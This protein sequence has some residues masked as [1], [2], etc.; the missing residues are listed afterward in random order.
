MDIYN[1]S[2]IISCLNLCCQQV[3]MLVYRAPA[4]VQ[5]DTD[6]VQLIGCHTVWHRSSAA[7]WSAS[8]AGVYT[9]TAA[10]HATAKLRH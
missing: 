6:K 3:N 1:V 10:V 4:V 7:D 9:A 2:H 8:T 5:L